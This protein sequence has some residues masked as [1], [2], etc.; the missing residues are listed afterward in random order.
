MRALGTNDSGIDKGCDKV[1]I[2]TDGN[3]ASRWCRLPPLSVSVQLV[4]GRDDFAE[5]GSAS[6]STLRATDALDLSN[7][8]RPAKL[9]RVTDVTDPRSFGCGFAALRCIA[10]S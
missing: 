4:A 9:L 7:A 8:G 6:R 2:V 5:R 3:P 1:R 10:R